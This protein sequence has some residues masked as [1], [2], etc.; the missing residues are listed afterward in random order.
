MMQMSEKVTWMK[1]I[2]KAKYALTLEVKDHKVTLDADT[3][4]DLMD[5]AGWRI[6]DRIIE[7]T[8]R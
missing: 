7:R 4:A 8:D 1:F 5:Q 2:R 6:S 3:F